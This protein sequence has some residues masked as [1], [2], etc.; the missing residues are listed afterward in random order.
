MPRLVMQ[1]Q[2]LLTWLAH[3]AMKFEIRAASND[4][5]LADF[6]RSRWLEMGVDDSAC[7]AD[8]RSTA[9]DFMASAREDRAFAGFV[10]ASDGA[11]VGGACCQR[12]DRVFPAFR[13]DDATQIGYLWGLY[14]IPAAR[15]RGIGA[16]LVNACVA[17][18]A[19]Q[20]CRRVPLHAGERSRALYAKLGFR[21]TDEMGLSI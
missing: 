13:A 11:D 9:L 12:V 16:A 2:G 21:A 1:R 6:Y 15:G 17:H 20:G 8:W 14:V 5:L 19:D 7:V 10:A 18:L 4:G 3:E